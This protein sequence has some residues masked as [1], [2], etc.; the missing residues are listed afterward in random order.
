MKKKMDTESLNLQ[1]TCPIIPDKSIYKPTYSI[2]MPITENLL[3]SLNETPI[4]TKF[5][6]PSPDHQTTYKMLVA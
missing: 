5:I 1:N 2:S 4:T 3:I 6:N